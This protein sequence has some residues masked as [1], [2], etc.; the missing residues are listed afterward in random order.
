MDDEGQTLG[1]GRAKVAEEQQ[2]PQLSKL[3][4]VLASKSWPSENRLPV[5]LI[6]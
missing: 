4:P 5:R 3:P 6:C 1:R 2:R